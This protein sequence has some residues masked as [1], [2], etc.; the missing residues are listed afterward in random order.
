MI[1]ATLFF[2]TLFV[3]LAILRARAM[4]EKFNVEAETLPESTRCKIEAMTGW[5]I[6]CLLDSLYF[7]K[8]NFVTT[9]LLLLSA[10]SFFLADYF[11]PEGEWRYMGWLVGLFAIIF[12]FWIYL[13]SRNFKIK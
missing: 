8:D 10:G 12:S 13:A 9:A 6:V 1:I 4:L 7:R 2:G 3:A 5:E 11:Y